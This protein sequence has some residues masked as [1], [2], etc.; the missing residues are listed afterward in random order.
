MSDPPVVYCQSTDRNNRIC[1]LL[2]AVLMRSAVRPQSHE[3]AIQ[4]SFPWSIEAS[5]RR[6]LVVLIY[7]PKQDNEALMLIES[8]QEVTNLLPKI[9][10]DI[11]ST[12]NGLQARLSVLDRRAAVFVV[13]LGCLPVE[14][15]SMPNG[16][17]IS[18]LITVGTEHALVAGDYSLSFPILCIVPDSGT[19]TSTTT[20]PLQHTRHVLLYPNL[21]VVI[22]RNRS[23]SSSPS[24]TRL[25]T[26]RTVLLFVNAVAN[27]EANAWARL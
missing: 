6:P 8:I 14:L 18:G 4:E 19:T 17:N 16:G 9:M 11:V 13:A 10:I 23:S 27:T 2:S 12:S 3:A 7:S 5:T 22:N 26:T 21:I 25:W 20:T 1:S 24:Y 15:Q